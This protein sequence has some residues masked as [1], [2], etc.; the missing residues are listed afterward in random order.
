[1]TL[2]ATRNLIRNANGTVNM[3]IDHSVYGWI[4]FTADPND[5]EQHGKD[6]YAAAVAGA[7]GAIAPYIAPIP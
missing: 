7:L 5:S 3:E 1:M 6:L 4:P 2:P